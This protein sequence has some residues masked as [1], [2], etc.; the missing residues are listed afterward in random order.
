MK[1]RILVWANKGRSEEIRFL[2]HDEDVEIP[3]AMSIAYGIKDPDAKE[4]VITYV[5]GVMFEHGFDRNSEHIMLS[6]IHI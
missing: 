3:P 6:L 2:K 5:H 4:Q 1:I